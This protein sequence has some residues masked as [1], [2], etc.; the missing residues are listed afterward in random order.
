MPA[1]QRVLGHCA[2]LDSLAYYI[3]CRRF[4]RIRREAGGGGKII[5]VT[6]VHEEI[7][8]GAAGYDCAKGAEGYKSDW[9]EN[10]TI[11]ADAQPQGSRAA[12][13]AAVP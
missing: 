6:S 7:P 12:V 10:W 5:N 8:R 1:L 9:T 11:Y 3:R 13:R 2:F 4:I